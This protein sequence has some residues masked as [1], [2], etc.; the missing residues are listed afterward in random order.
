MND[1]SKLK[2]MTFFIVT[3]I[4]IFTIFAL[5]HKN[6]EFLYYTIIMS[7]L[8][9]ILIKYYNKMQLTIGIASGLVILACLH[10]LG[11]N[12]IIN[13]SRLYEFW[14]IKNFFRY[15]NL[16]HTI[17]SFVATLFSY[18][19]IYPHL[20]EETKRKKLI[21][22]II[23]V[24]MACGIGTLNEIMELGAVVWLDAAPQV[25]D[26]FNNAIDLVF[27]IIGSIL[28]VIYLFYIKPKSQLDY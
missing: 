14:I 19:L 24:L 11:G 5:I 7:V 6:F 2:A 25:G 27:N 12:L 18:S 16:V 26:Y 17:G 22:I 8:I 28:A 4:L 10:I 1:K 15:D 9:I 21:P 3:Y 20:T 13:N 23:I